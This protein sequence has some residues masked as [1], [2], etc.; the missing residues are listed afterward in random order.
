MR[1][2]E[3]GTNVRIEH[4]ARIVALMDKDNP[5]WYEV[6]Y[7][8]G[9]RDTV[10]LARINGIVD[11]SR[12]VIDTDCSIQ[13]FSPRLSASGALDLLLWLETHRHEFEAVVTSPQEVTEQEETFE[14]KQEQAERDY[15]R[16]VLREE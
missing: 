16:E 6:E 10:S 15:R 12:A 3:P 8:D 11:R 9:T 4:N 5:Y 7:P 2:L 14:V 13:I 1:K